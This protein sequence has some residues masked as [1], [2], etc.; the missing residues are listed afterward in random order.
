[1]MLVGGR[2]N[3]RT[4]LPT[5]KSTSFSYLGESSV[6]RKVGW[7]GGRPSVMVCTKSGPCLFLPSKETFC[8]K[9]C[10]EDDRGSEGMTL[11]GTVWEPN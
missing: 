3:S 1:M 9:K 7:V 10:F 5:E 8:N 4:G 11:R 6:C 2:G